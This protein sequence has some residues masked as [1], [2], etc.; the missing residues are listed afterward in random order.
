MTTPAPWSVVDAVTA[1][2]AAATVVLTGVGLGVGLLAL[3]GYRDI[4][5]TAVQRA[6]AEARRVAEAVAAREIG[7]FLDKQGTGTDISQA[8][9]D[10][11]PWQEP[12]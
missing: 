8:Y 11:S 10:Q 6:E 7:A 5:R 1:A 4:R 12:G 2:L 3:W 9:Q